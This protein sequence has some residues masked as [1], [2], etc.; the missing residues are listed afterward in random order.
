[1]SGDR[2]R[3]FLGAAIGI[4]LALGLWRW[5]AHLIPVDPTGRLPYRLRLACA[6]LLPAACVLNAM[7]VVQMRL[8]AVSGALDPLAGQ[9]D[10]RL[11]VNQRVISNTVEQLAG[12][13]PAMLAVAAGVSPGWMSF[14]VA[15][16]LVFAAARLVFWAGYM[17]GPLL[18]APGMAAT[19]GVNIGTLLAAVW[20]W[21]P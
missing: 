13:V 9:D 18:R 21:W 6:S 1:V 4:G 3:A 19:F 10:W 5:L 2:F 7:I 8:R 17:L 15:A 20:V 14:V 11:L 12:F 16:G